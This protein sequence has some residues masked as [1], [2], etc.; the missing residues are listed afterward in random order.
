MPSDDRLDAQVAKLTAEPRLEL[1][2]GRRWGQRRSDAVRWVRGQLV[3]KQCVLYLGLLGKCA[4]QRA[5][6]ACIWIP[7]QTFTEVDWLAAV[8][9]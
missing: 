7:R 6:D 2:R 1:R 5:A 8:N 4:R 3:M 9:P